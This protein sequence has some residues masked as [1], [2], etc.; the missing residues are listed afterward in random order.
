MTRSNKIK[1]C[2]NCGAPLEQDYNYCPFCGL[3]LREYLRGEGEPSV[4]H[5]V[6]LELERQ[7]ALVSRTRGGIRGVKAFLS[8]LGFIFLF[9]S[10]TDV[11]MSFN[12]KLT[13]I[14]YVPFDVLKFL[15]EESERMKSTDIGKLIDL[16]QRLPS[17]LKIA[18]YLFVLHF[19]FLIVAMVFGFVS[20]FSGSK[21]TSIATCISQFASFGML[22][23][24]ASRL[25]KLATLPVLGYSLVDYEI[26]GGI[27][28][29]FIS[30]ILYII[31]SVVA[32]RTS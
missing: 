29:L 11:W 3:N 27:M 31:S 14:N 2:P 19:V 10:I 12:L 21:S 18:V 25:F 28:V 9:I 22:L 13:K 6:L 17:D 16:L 8:L 32:S 4:Y 30:I 7:R 5:K 26:Q 20:I 23:A 15:L 1:Y 24:F